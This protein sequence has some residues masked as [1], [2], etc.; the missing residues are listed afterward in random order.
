MDAICSGLPPVLESVTVCVGL[1]VF[2]PWL[3]KSRL[4][5]DTVAIGLMPLPDRATVIGPVGAS[6]LMVS[7]PAAGPTALGV[8]P[9]WIEQVPPGEV[10][11]A[12]AQL[13]V[14]LTK[15][16]SPLIDMELT[17]RVAPPGLLTVIVRFAAAVFNN[18][19]PNATLAGLTLI[20]G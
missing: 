14:T 17:C 8:N 16:G 19:L 2:S 10:P 3:P 7:V 1:L 18:W 12:P 4:E 6:L 15:S 20:P 11:M 9:T 5:G 13:S